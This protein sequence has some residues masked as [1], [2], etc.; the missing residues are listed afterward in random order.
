MGV[1]I[2]LREELC[3]CSC[4]LCIVFHNVLSST[5]S[6]TNHIFD[7]RSDTQVAVNGKY[8]DDKDVVSEVCATLQEMFALDAPP[9][10]V[11]SH[12]TRWA[13]DELAK[14][15]YSY[16]KVYS[17]SDMCDSLAVPEWGGRLCFA[18]E[19]CCQDRVQCVDGALVTGRQAADT[20]AAL[21]NGGG[22]GASA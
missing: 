13:Q 3:S 18:G 14:G 20:V 17:G 6:H 5:D 16:Q 10:P 2:V 9:V 11:D 21:A 7:H 22:R 1:T 8:Y 4:T 15:S 19:A 12:V